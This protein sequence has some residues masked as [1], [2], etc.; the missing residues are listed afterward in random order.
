MRVCGMRAC[1]WMTAFVAAVLILGAPTAHAATVQALSDVVFTA[2]AGET[3]DLTVTSTDG[4]SF[5]LEDAG[6]ALSAGS[7]CTQENARRVT[8][9][10]PLGSQPKLQIDLGDDSDTLDYSDRTAPVFADLGSTDGVDGEQGE[11]DKAIDFERV[12]G[13][14][15]NDRLTGSDA[16]NVLSGGPGDDRL[17]GRARADH[18]FGG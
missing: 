14:D 1:G 7:G 9:K 4:L 5:T 2:A 6:A 10:L 18:L 3:N 16:I 11:Q 17:I 13:G 15:G 8:C 12:R